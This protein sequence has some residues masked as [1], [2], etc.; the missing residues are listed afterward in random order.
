MPAT[1]VS[2]LGALLEAKE[3]CTF[4][5]LRLLSHGDICEHSALIFLDDSSLRK[6]LSLGLFMFLRKRQNLSLS[7]VVL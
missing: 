7:K 3:K 1:F 4:V 6:V 2:L 5:I